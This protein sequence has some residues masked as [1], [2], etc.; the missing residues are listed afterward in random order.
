MTDLYEPFR[1]EMR[2]R[3]G[4]CGPYRL[5]IAIGEAGSDLTSPRGYTPRSIQQFDAGRKV[6]EARRNREEAEREIRTAIW[7]A[8]RTGGMRDDL[9]QALVRRAMEEPLMR[10]AIGRL[11]R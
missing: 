10:R 5:G 4:Y 7:N 3:H 2:R 6:G 8:C 9:S 11:G 1:A